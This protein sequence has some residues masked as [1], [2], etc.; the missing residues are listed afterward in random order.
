MLRELGGFAHSAGSL[1]G[2]DDLLVQE[3]ARRG[4]AP[5]R[6]VWSAAAA[7]PSA[8]PADAR[9]FWRQKRRHAGAG[10]H[11]PPAV[12]A[13]L[14]L[15][16][17]SNLGLW[18]G[19]PLLHAVGGVPYGWGLLAVKLLLQR[20]V[21]L[22]AFDALGAEADLHVWQP[23][24]DGLSAAYHAAFAVLGGA[25]RPGAMV[26]A[27][28]PAAAASRRPPNPFTAPSVSPE[29]RDRLSARDSASTP[30]EPRRER[31][32]LADGYW[33]F[34]LR[35][36]AGGQEPSAESRHRTLPTTTS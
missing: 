33:R 30:Y 20:A 36:S 25:P 9:A 5:V 12:L 22:P 27:G 8:A 26:T 15:F 3:V 23:V 35:R 7:V 24:L 19:A 18:L 31:S 10:A 32:F 21:L 2:D 29:T 1:S 16:H 28:P 4:A 11:Y 34:T 14:G 6:P 17:A 13:A